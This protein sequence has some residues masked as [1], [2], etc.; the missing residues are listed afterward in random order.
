M[1]QIVYSCFFTSLCHAIIQAP[2]RRL[3]ITPVLFGVGVDVDHI[4]GSKYI[5]DELAMLGFSISS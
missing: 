3:V 5:V 2:R 1:V 4:C